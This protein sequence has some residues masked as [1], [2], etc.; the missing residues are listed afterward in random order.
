M[1]TARTEV[2]GA[3]GVIVPRCR[4]VT[5]KP[6]AESIGAATTNRLVSNSKPATPTQ[7]ARSSRRYADQS[8]MVAQKPGISNVRNQPLIIDGAGLHRRALIVPVI[9]D[10]ACDHGERFQP[11]LYHGLSM[12]S[13]RPTR[14]FIIKYDQPRI[15]VIASRLGV[16]Y[17]P[18]TEVYHIISSLAAGLIAGTEA[19]R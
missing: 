19:S 5:V 18:S 2:A 13:L 11:K 3:A 9:M 14:R 10:D 15:E 7:P 4:C 17:H 8:A 1:L 12:C 6:E 16:P